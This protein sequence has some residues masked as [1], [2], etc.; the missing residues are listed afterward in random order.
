MARTD[1]SSDPTFRELLDYVESSLS[2]ATSSYNDAYLDRR[3]SA[4]M[5]RRGVESYDEYQ[6]L[7]DDDEEEQTALLNALS[8]NVTSFFRNPE[9]WDALREVIADI[10]S[11]SRVNIWSAACSDGREAYSMAMLAHDDDRIDPNKVKILGTDIKPEIIRAARA[12]EYHASET[13]DIEEQLE[14]LSQNNRYVERDGD[15]Y[16]VTDEVKSLV[17]FRKHDLVQERPPDTFDLVVCRNL[18]IYI[19]SEAKQAIFDTLGSALTPDGYLTIGMTETIPPSCRDRFD[20][21]EKRL[22]IYRNAANSN[23]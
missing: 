19:N 11:D 6:S 16:R 10:A 4:R 17:S 8:V 12:G 5:R 21:V 20:P 18:F 15:I 13:N 14:P 3:I 9:V 23:P 2:F 1:S 7:L 22:R